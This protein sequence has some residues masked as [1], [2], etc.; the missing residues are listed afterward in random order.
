MEDT[1][2]VRVPGGSLRGDES[3]HDAGGQTIVDLFFETA[4]R[5][6]NEHQR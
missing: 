3:G 4:D 6:E 2:Y 1:V 5:A